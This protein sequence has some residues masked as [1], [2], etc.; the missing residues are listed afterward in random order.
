MTLALS[1]PSALSA[2]L[3]RRWLVAAALVLV[4]MGV[5]GFWGSVYTHRSFFNEAEARGHNTL[6]LA[7]AVLRGHMARY[8]NLPEVIAG[9]DEIQDLLAAPDNPALID[10]VN[11]YLK[12]I[13][14]QF[15]SSDIYV[16]GMDGTTIVASN[17][18]GERPFVG[19]NF[20]YRPYF[21]DAIDGGEGRFFAL[22]T[23]SFK[24]G[25]YFGAPVVVGGETLGVVAVKIDV[26]T[27]EDT[28]RGGGDYQI[29]VNDPEGIIFMTSEPNWLYN[30][31]L[32]LTR[33]RLARTAETRRYANAEL[34]ELPLAD[35]SDENHRLYTIAGN[36]A[37]TEYLVVSESMP[38]A[39]WTVSVLLDT[40]SARAQALTAIVIALLA[41]AM[42]ILAGAVVIQGRARLRER[43][44]MQRDA[45]EL[46]ERRVIERTAEL[47]SVN[48]KLEE[49]VAERRATEARLRKTQSDLIQAGKLAALGRMSADL[50]HEFNQP[51]AAARNYADN[52]LV[53]FDRGRIEDARRTV[54]NISGII[55]RM[56]AL[57]RHLRNFARKPNE[58]LSTVPLGQ[59]VADTVQLIDWRIK[60][61]GIDLTIDI[62]PGLAVMGGPNRLEQVLLNVLANAM[63][64]V[65]AG[66]DRRILLSASRKAD[67]VTILVRDH[68]P[69]ITAGA[70]ERIFDPFFSTKGT[71]KGLGLGLS[72]SYNIIKDFGGELHAG[73]HPEGGALF[74][75]ELNAADI[76][77]I[78]DAAQ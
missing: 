7:I 32:P 27:I 69:G 57:S 2:R 65:E 14:E 64:A 70:N 29:I 76:E 61:S 21:F 72:I 52:A 50:S 66:E 9:F 37:S 46:L 75:I 6:R 12:E 55:D 59:V 13:N 56:T 68:G 35:V 31:V 26:E 18:D 48:N 25:Y 73:N 3:R 43:M 47:A 24:R 36:A 15:R 10:E 45:K 51:L 58:K 74:T 33:E 67:R 20:Q 1:I 49:E 16:M 34:R 71:G 11:H 60:A 38:E 42:L 30:S 77:P 17:F 63:D 4:G 19:D 8:E 28:W 53:L 39:D 40:S 62:P 23:T 5:V 54:A 22:G 78:A 41:M 44:Q